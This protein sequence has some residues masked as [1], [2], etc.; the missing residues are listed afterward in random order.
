MA[1]ARRARRSSTSL[2]RKPTG[3]S[4]KQSK[5][6]RPSTSPSEDQS[7][8]DIVDAD[9]YVETHDSVVIVQ[10]LGGAGRVMSDLAGPS[11]TAG[12]HRSSRRIVQPAL[13]TRKVVSTREIGIQAE[14]TQE[15]VPVGTNSGNSDEASAGSSSSAANGPAAV[16]IRP[17]AALLYDD[18]K[19]RLEC[20]V[21][22]KISLPPVMQCR[23]GHVTCNSCRLKVR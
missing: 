11:G 21:C 2:H 1:R 20:P 13:F 6:R 5:R 12:D 17:E 16:A 18:M 9:V 23:N 15:L 8:V 19:A 3:G 22:C 7:D 14:E 4:S 10:D